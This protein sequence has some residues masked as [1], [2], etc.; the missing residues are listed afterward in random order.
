MSYRGD[1][2][3]G[4]TL[5]VKFTTRRFSTGAPYTLAGIPAVAAYVGN[6]TTEITAGITLTVDFDGRTGLNNVRVVASSGNG[7]ASATDVQLV[8]TSGTVDGV[9]VAGEVIA[10]FSIENRPMTAHNLATQA[11]ADVNAEVDTAFDTPFPGIVTSGSLNAALKGHVPQTGDS[12]ARIGATGSGLTSLASQ[13]S[14]DAID[15]IVDAILADT[16]TDLPA[17]LATIAGYID[18]EVAAIKA[19]T[20][21]LPSDP[22]DQSAVEAAITSAVAAL[23]TQASVDVIDALIDAIKAKTDNLPSDPADQSAVEAAITAATSPLATAAALAAV[24]AFVDTEVAAIKAKTDNLPAS[25]AAVGSAMTL[26]SGERDAVAAAI[27]DL[28]DGVETSRTVRAALRLI[29]ATAVGK[30]SG[31]GTTAIAIR[32]TNDTKDRIAATV[33]ASGNRTAVTLDAT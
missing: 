7:F 20:D 10:E 2:R 17:L 15:S 4:S 12:F 6:G 13:A 33:D 16:G 9:S 27:L 29:L 26:T 31:A 3:L 1:I 22:A 25:P 8:L 24:A 28:A 11:K 30:L 18:T 14:V 19:K 21:N 5:D 23:A 32:D